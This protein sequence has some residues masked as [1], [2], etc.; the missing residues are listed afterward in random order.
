MAVIA[1]KRRHT[2]TYYVKVKWDGKEHWENAGHDRREAYRLNKA[3]I[4]SIQEGTFQPKGSHKPPTVREFADKWLTGRTCRW[5]QDEE[6]FFRTYV[7]SRDWLA[8]MDVEDL[9]AKHTQ[10]LVAELKLARSERFDRP[11]AANTVA[12]IYGIW[13]VMCRDARIAGV[14]KT[15][16][17]VLPKGTLQRRQKKTK[18]I[19][20]PAE[21]VAKILRCSALHPTARVFCAI[22]F[23]T[24]MREGE[25]C[26]RRWRDWDRASKPLGCLT[27][28]SQYDG[29]MLKGDKF[30]AGEVARRVPVHP[31]LAK[32]LDWWWSEGFALVHCRAPTPDD[33]IVPT[34]SGEPYGRSA[35]YSMFR[36][37]LATAG[38]DNRTL[39]ATRNTFLTLCRRGGAR[40]DV[41]ERVTHNASGD[42]IDH[43]T[44]WDWAPL[45]EAVMGLQLPSSTATALPARLFPGGDVGGDD[46][47]ESGCSEPTPPGV[48][49]GIE[50]ESI[51]PDSSGS[52][53][54]GGDEGSEKQ[55][56]CSVVSVDGAARH[57]P[58]LGPHRVAPT[59]PEP[60]VH[61]ATANLYELLA[62]GAP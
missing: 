6:T 60:W 46:T 9:E 1:R 59:R 58:L 3:T 45:C 21:D 27:V 36:R 19:P 15:D 34:A 53:V 56:V 17:C 49:P 37:A 20:Y 23:L 55:A 54:F 41:I 62:R 24:G 13:R 40:K 39:H 8:D 10:Q 61:E 51:R 11:L 52:G 14:L 4:K 16:V 50:A 29:Q 28:D 12:T 32:I 18:R 26:G 7:L 30:E 31:E 38:V 33:F 5:A 22:A 42:T 57:P 35:A 44:Y 43:Y 2:T 25:V 47:N 48:V